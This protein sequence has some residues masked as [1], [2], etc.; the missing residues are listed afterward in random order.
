MKILLITNPLDKSRNYICRQIQIA[1]DAE[2][3]NDNRKNDKDFLQES[4]YFKIIDCKDKYDSFDKYFTPEVVY[5]VPELMWANDDVNEGYDIAREFITTKYKSEY[6][7]VAFLSVLDRSKLAKIV[8]NRNKSFV[9]AFPHICLL[10]DNLKIKFEYFSEIHFNLIKHLAISNEGRLQRISHE[11]NSVK[12]NILRKTKDVDLNKT[13]LLE[14][15]EELTLFQQWTERNLTDEITKIRKATDNNNLA[16]VS[17]SIENIIDEINIKL[18]K[19]GETNE[20]NIRKKQE[21][22]IKL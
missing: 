20:I 12:A 8:D 7:Q 14:S 21:V 17:K 22:N 1:W 2:V 19:E 3:K 9:E 10:D 16:S 6:I 15:L 5:I 4:E 11:M 13:D 18:P